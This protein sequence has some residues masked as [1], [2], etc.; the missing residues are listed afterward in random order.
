VSISF[1][2]YCIVRPISVMSV[3]AV[4]GCW[5]MYLWHI[6]SVLSCFGRDHTLKARC[7]PTPSQSSVLIGHLLCSLVTLN[8]EPL[9]TRSYCACVRSVPRVT[10]IVSLKRWTRHPLQRCWRKWLPTQNWKT[11]KEH[12]KQTMYST[13]RW[14]DIICTFRYYL[15]HR[16]G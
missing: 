12:S 8:N 14:D 5:I 13:R 16:P 11:R 10:S 2:Y 9:F 1:V 15:G 6:I 7:C 3:I 4:L